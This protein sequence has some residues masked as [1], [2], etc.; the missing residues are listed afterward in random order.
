[1]SLILPTKRQFLKSLF[2]A[3]AI[4]ASTNIMKV[5]AFETIEKVTGFDAVETITGVVNSNWNLVR[6]GEKFVWMTNSVLQTF[7]GETE[8]ISKFE[9]PPQINRTEET[10]ALMKQ[11]RGST[12]IWELPTMFRKTPDSLYKRII[13]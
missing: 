3:P 4:V 5:K 6:N 9:L 11:H 2:I 8:L 7:N 1:M 13:T 12:V 10:V